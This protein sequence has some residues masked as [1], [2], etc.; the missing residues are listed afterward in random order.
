M[1][2]YLAVLVLLMLSLGVTNAQNTDWTLWVYAEQS[3]VPRYSGMLHEV[4]ATGVLQ[5]IELPIELGVTQGY[6][7]SDVAI[8]DDLRF[9]ALTTITENGTVFRLFDRDRNICCSDLTALLGSNVSAINLGQFE[10]NGSR[11]AFSYV[12]EDRSDGQNSPFEGGIAIYNAAN[13]TM[14]RIVAMNGLDIE[15]QYAVWAIMGDWTP[16]GIEY[17]PMCYA[18]DGFPMGNYSVWN[19]QTNSILERG[20]RFVGFAD[21]LDATGEVIRWRED[22]RFPYSGSPTM[23]GNPNV[24][25]YG[26]NTV[27]EASPVIFHS[28]AYLNISEAHW[29]G[30]GQSILVEEFQTS[31]WRLLNRDT[32]ETIPLPKPES[33]RVLE[34]TPTGWLATNTD[35]NGYATQLLHY[36]IEDASS[37]T[38]LNLSPNTRLRVVRDIPLGNSN[39]VNGR[40]ITLNPPENVYVECPG[41]LPTRLQ[42]GEGGRVTPG[43]ANRMRQSPYIDA[44]VV[45]SIP[46][47]AQFTV[48]SGP[49]C[50]FENGIA[51]WE[52][53]FNGTIGWT[54]E[55]QGDTYWTEPIR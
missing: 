38:L 48:M 28:P 32:P 30:D 54:A 1:K 55:G 10:P 46:G 2:K 25:Q 49:A 39:A 52:V 18:C 22:T 8:S 44:E 31:E 21:T 34:G 41:F 13:S 26:L 45:G 47:G 51:W 43:A 40:F 6:N 5:T 20:G 3:N 4:N 50:D 14:E 24:I 11:L 35:D 29:V 17:T 23:F 33:V 16:Q 27:N 53:N 9:V 36:N 42:A 12:M 7:T 37:R 19:P 15:D